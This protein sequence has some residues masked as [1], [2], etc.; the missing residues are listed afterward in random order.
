MTIAPQRTGQPDPATQIARLERRLAREREARMAAEAIAESGILALYQQQER[1]RIVQAVATAANLGDDPAIAFAE[2]LREVCAFT[3]W[4]VGYVCMFDDD[5]PSRLVSSGVWYG[6]DEPHLAPFREASAHITFTSGVGLPGRVLAAKAGVWVEDVTLEPN[7]PRALAAGRGALRGGF[8]FPALIGEEVGAVIEFFQRSAVPP[9]PELLDMLNQ[10][11]AQLGRVVERYRNARRLRIHN[12]E[13]T[14]L[15]AEAQGQKEAAEAASRAKSNFLAVTSHEVRTPLN[16]VLGLSEALK[17]EP[18]TVAQHELN[19]GVLASGQ[20]LLRLLDAVLDMSRIEANQ[21]TARLSDFDIRAKLQ[22][23]ISIWTPQAQ[24]MGVVLRLD[25]SRLDLDRIRQD[26]GRVEQTLVNLISNAFKFTPAD[27]E[28]RIVAA[29]ANNQLRLEVIDGGP[30]VPEADRER[31]FEAFE[32]TDSGRAIGGAGLG[33]SI[34]VGNVRVLEGQICAD[35]TDDGRS[36]FW[37]SCPVGDAAPAEDL[38]V[39][40]APA[41]GLRVLAAEDNAGNRRV[42]Q[43]LLA[44]AGVELTLVE[45][46]LQAVEALRAGRFD[47]ILMDANMPV[48]DGPTA[49]RQ[50]RAENIA[51]VAAVHML[52]ANVFAEDIARYLAAGADGVLAKPIQLPLLFAVLAECHDADVGQRRIG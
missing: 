45:N 1:L 22:A 17:R 46:G 23:I 20:M 9:D 15:Y 6:A 47:L 13:L 18:L 4:P 7:F 40:L 5:D 38:P 24:E 10:I 11:G 50:I 30:G 35:R 27:A 41:R 33:L 39:P 14:T 37:F 52:T 49:V 21:A 34:C 12:A 3:G 19:D 44:P 28:V 31:I 43:V 42:L 25:T 48:M 29:S 51:G 32:Q 2:A 26:E 8:A 16:A 36:R